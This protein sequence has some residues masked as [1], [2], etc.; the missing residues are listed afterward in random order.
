MV[1]TRK[2]VAEHA[3]V[4]ESTAGMILA[5]R[6]QRYS[7]HTREKVLASAKA[8]DY[9]PNPAARSLQSQRSFLIG[10]LINSSNAAISTEFLR[11]V[12]AVL[13]S[14]DYSPI[15][16]S[17]A[18]CEEQAKCLE[19]CTD[20]RVDGLIVNASHD[21]SGRFDTSHLAA[22][23][24]QGTPVIEVF[25][26][27]IS[28]VPQINVDNVAAGRKSVEHLLGL[29]HRR[30]AMLTHERYVVGRS[31]RAAMHF[32]AWERYCGYEEAMYD[33]GLEP[34]VVTHPITGEVDVAQQFVD[35]GL[36]AFDSLLSHP[37]KPTAV[38]CYNDL[39]VYGL[40][41]AARLKGVK[42]NDHFSVVGFGDLDHSRIIVPALTTVPV[43]AFEVGRRAAEALLDSLD[44]QPVESALIETEI[45][46]RESTN[47]L[48]S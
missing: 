1:V 38:I 26:R 14:G 27:F 23:I 32:D 21:A 28:G 11:G 16:L 2:D 42:I 41:R 48:V 33:A 18:D 37:A 30:I 34:V 39:E 31:G 13:N 19:R 43:P 20:R 3:Q 25:G 46:V 29:G 17:H 22:A 45:V 8:L 12:Q 5:G 10:V 24:E 35:G 9:R 7:I 15:V 44:E 4:S 6:G 36:E 40:I 47:Q